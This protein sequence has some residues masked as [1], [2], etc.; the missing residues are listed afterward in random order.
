MSDSKHDTSW[1]VPNIT[2]DKQAIYIDGHHIDGNT[3]ERGVHIHW[4]GDNRIGP[5]LTLTIH[6]TNIEV[7][8]AARAFNAECGGEQYT[9]SG[10]HRE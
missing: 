5:S 7:T 6:A 10:Y 9:E 8:E 3:I 2:L 1:A 4:G